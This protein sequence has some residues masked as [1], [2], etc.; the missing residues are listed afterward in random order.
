MSEF[1]L[2]LQALREEAMRTKEEIFFK[3]RYIFLLGQETNRC[4][5]SVSSFTPRRVCD[6]GRG[7]RL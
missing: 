6:S 2:E 1:Q 5:L 7:A 3:T 4:R